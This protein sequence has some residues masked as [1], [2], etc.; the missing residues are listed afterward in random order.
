MQHCSGCRQPLMEGVTVCLHCG[1]PVPRR[2]DALANK[3]DF[4]LVPALPDE[5][6]PSGG[7]WNLN[8]SVPSPYGSIPPVDPPPPPLYA[9]GTFDASVGVN[10]YVPT[11][12][13][14]P[15]ASSMLLTI[16]VLLIL[17]GGGVGARYAF[18]GGLRSPFAQAAA[19]KSPSTT[20]GATSERCALPSINAAQ[21]SNISHAQLTTGL[22]DVDRHDYSPINMVNTFTT[23]QTVYVTFTIASNEAASFSAEWC[24]GSQDQVTPF[25]LQIDMN[26]KGIL[27]YVDLR[28]LDARAVGHCSVILRWNNAI[29]AALPFT[30][31]AK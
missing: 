9:S 12:P 30:V 3:N 23:G 28:D 2:S 17:V 24:L 7:N 8:S 1:T 18:T 4:L 26:K 21:S 13:H 15:V 27:G 29:V 31:T 11:K 14:R 10:P 22:R 6:L 25:T 19:T 20:G 16:F 5:G